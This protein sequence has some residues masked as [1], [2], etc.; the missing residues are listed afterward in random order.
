[1]ES[2]PVTSNR[3][4]FETIGQTTNPLM[5]NL[6]KAYKSRGCNM[7]LY[8]IFSLTPR[9]F[10]TVLRSHERRDRRVI[11]PIHCKNGKTVSGQMDL[12]NPPR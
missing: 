5:E 1:M 3:V 2:P 4:F 9:I 8:N 11:S 6:L 7:V 10:S 12:V